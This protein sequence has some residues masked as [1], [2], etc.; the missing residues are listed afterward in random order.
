MGTPA[1]YEQNYFRFR[2]DDDSE[3]AAT[4]REL[5]N[6]D[7]IY[8]AGDLDV[9]NRLRIGVAETGGNIGANEDV[10]FQYSLN[11]GAWTNISTTSSVVKAIATAHFN[12]M[13]DTTQQLTSGGFDGS[14]SCSETGEC[15]GNQLDPPANGF[16]EVELCF[17]V[18]SGDVSDGDTI[19]IRVLLDLALDEWNQ[20]PRI[21]ISIPSGTQYQ[22]SV[23]GSF[24]AQSGALGRKAAF[25]RDAEGAMPGQAGG[26]ERKVSLLRLVLGDVD[27]TPDLTRKADFKRH[28][29]GD[30]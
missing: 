23:D 8:E 4:W 12:D 14:T 6:I 15:G 27:W 11:S 13:D 26:L 25:E 5:L 9:N 7:T 22:R 19:D 29:E 17:Q 30:I 28:T 16:S 2:D 10:Q 21:T 18:I 1:Y 24:P 3:A 20:V